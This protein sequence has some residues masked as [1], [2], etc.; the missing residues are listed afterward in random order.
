MTNPIRRLLFV[1][2]LVSL[3]GASWPTEPAPPADAAPWR[4]SSLG[5]ELQDVVVGTGDEVV[6]GARVYV[7]YVGMLSDGTVFDES[8]P[9]GKAFDF[10]VGAGQVIQGWEDGL[11]G[12]KVGGTRRLVIPSSLGYGAQGQGSIP[13]GATLYFEVDLLS[14]KPPRTAPTEVP[15]LPG[16]AWKVVQDASVADVKVGDGKRIKLKKGDRACLDLVQFDAEGAVLS[17]TYARERCA[18]TQLGWGKLPPTVEAGLKGLRE[19][20]VRAIRDGDTVWLV[21]LTMVGI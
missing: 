3:L 21:E 6:E 17:S 20:G 1:P 10:L 7:H 5:V 8:R 11:L 13:G 18:W 9:R 12:M 19:R 2:L 14:L 16:D 4:R 15:E